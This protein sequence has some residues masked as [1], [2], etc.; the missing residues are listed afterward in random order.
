MHWQFRE[1]VEI[2]HPRRFIHFLC[3]LIGNFYPK[4]LVFDCNSILDPYPCKIM[5]V[6]ICKFSS[7]W[8]KKNNIILCFIFTKF[9]TLK[10]CRVWK[11]KSSATQIFTWK[12]YLRSK[13]SKKVILANSESLPFFLTIGVKKILISWNFFSK[14]DEGKIPYAMCSSPCHK[15]FSS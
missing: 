9:G 4:F 12:Q 13:T 6:L 5:K 11:R 10:H 1:I 3:L 2:Q 8:K 14:C 7:I 15:L